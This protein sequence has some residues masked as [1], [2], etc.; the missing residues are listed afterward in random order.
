MV[1]TEAKPK[2]NLPGTPASQ[3]FQFKMEEKFE[4]LQGQFASQE[5]LQHLIRSDASDVIKICA[6]PAGQDKAVWILEHLRCALAE[7]HTLVIALD[8]V[9]TK[10]TCPMMIATKDWEFL[11]AAHPKEPKKCCAIDYTLHTLNGFTSLVN[12][13]ELFPSRVRVPPKST[14]VFGSIARRLYRVFAHAYFHHREQFDAFE[15]ETHLTKRY[16]TFCLM[17]ELM[18]AKEATPR[19]DIAGFK[20]DQVQVVK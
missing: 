8:R 2:R 20:M 19:M 17:H 10:D 13:A 7:L 16:L 6:V 11:C 4:D 18:T 3:L 15:A 12:N 9:C 5:Y 14:K 1:S